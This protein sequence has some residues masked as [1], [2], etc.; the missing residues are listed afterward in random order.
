MSDFNQSTPEP[1]NLRKMGLALTNK[2]SQI[3]GRQP[4]I[5]VVNTSNSPIVS[6]NS[7]SNVLADVGFD[8]DIAPKLKSLKNLVNQCIEN[9]ADV[10]MISADSTAIDLDLSEIEQHLLLNGFSCLLSLYL[11]DVNVPI[12]LKSKFKNWMIYDHNQ[13]GSG[14]A[15]D[16]LELLMR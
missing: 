1:N 4:R 9:D 8:V 16:V 15:Y 12:D 11:T 10:L 6:A 13:N 5:V 3:E 14:I 2:F 7:L